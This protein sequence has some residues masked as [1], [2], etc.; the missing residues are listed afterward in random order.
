MSVQ[1]DLADLDKHIGRSLTLLRANFH[2]AKNVDGSVSGGGGWYHQ[3]E[4]SVP[5]A[6]ATAVGL[7]AFNAMDEKPEMLRRALVFLRDKQV[8]SDDPLVDGGWATN[9]SSG[10]PVMEATA[11]VARAMGVTGCGVGPD[12][13]D[14]GRAFT[15]IVTNQNDDGGW[16]SIRTCPSRVWLTCLALNAL[17]SLNATAPAVER[18]VQWL[19]TN[20]NR[21]IYAWGETPESEPNVA[22]TALVLLT[23]RHVRPDSDPEMIRHAY[24]WLAANADMTRIGDHTEIYSTSVDHGRQFRVV[25]WHY[26]LPAV[27]AALLRHPDYPPP[28]L[29][30]RGLATIT[31]T[32]STG[33]FWPNSDS[34]TQ[35]SLWGVWWC[36]QALADVSRVRLVRADDLLTWTRDVVIVQRGHARGRT[37]A[38]LLPSRRKRRLRRI[39]KQYWLAILTVGLIL[40]AVGLIAAALIAYVG[41]TFTWGDFAIGT[42][43]PL[44]LFSLELIRRRASSKDDKARA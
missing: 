4:R 35:M 25:L 42:I 24:E 8:A 26:T 38:S 37:L 17:M 7:M 39:L 31:Q 12:A 15:W 14:A 20:R 28:D 44:L 30:A 9:S 1:I 34:G 21:R 10:V 13:P 2:M 40:S 36:V 27:V 22:H 11:W 5:G 33:G 19:L 3:L 23:L 43:F 6:T 18:G 41:G 32:Q 29:V 16:G